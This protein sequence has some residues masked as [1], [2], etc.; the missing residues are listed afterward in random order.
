M[1]SPQKY[2]FVI[3]PFSVEFRNTYDCAIKPALVECGTYCQRVDEMIF[4]E[5]MLS[6][7]Y[8]E[9]NKA[10]YIVADLSTKN[11]N[12]FYELGY[13]HALN[14][15]VILL[16]NNSD[17]IPFDL[18]QY[19]HCIYSMK[20]LTALKAELI[21]R[22]NHFLNESTLPEYLK[23]PYEL[24]INGKVLQNGFEY[25]INHNTKKTQ[26]SFEIEIEVLN[27]TMKY[28]DIGNNKVYLAVDETI[29]D[30]SFMSN[31]V[32]DNGK[33]LLPMN[34]LPSLFPLEKSRIFTSLAFQNNGIMNNYYNKTYNA[35]L[36]IHRFSNVTLIPFIFKLIKDF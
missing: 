5:N 28:H 20:N 31:I 29:I 15:T 35:E 33:A 30:R 1:T 19:Q 11:P 16:T 6:K 2:V 18:K 34:N 17:D 14:K 36:R 32:Y 8:N 22:M 26:N 10:D 9:I 25:T 23:L 3:M 27:N 4:T 7:I 21:A 12:V 13:A 24:M